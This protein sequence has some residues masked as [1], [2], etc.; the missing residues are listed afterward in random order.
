VSEAGSV[1][2]GRAELERAA[3]AVHAAHQ[4]APRFPDGQ[5]FLP[6]HEHT[7]GQRP[8][9]PTDALASLLLTAGVSPGRSRPT[10]RRGQLCSGTGWRASGCCYCWMT[11]LTAIRSGRCCLALPG[12]WCWS[13]AADT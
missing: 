2:F 6:L 9:G 13:P 1:L 5:I 11:R 7:P 3:F 12:T 8:V 10:Q 4:L